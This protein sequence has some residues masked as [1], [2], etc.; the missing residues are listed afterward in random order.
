MPDAPLNIGFFTDSYTPQVNGVAISMQLLVDSLRAKGQTVHIFAPRFRGWRDTD[1]HVHRLPARRYMD[2]PPFDIALPLSPSIWRTISRLKFDI[3]HMHTPLILGGLAFGIARRR[4]IPLIYTYHTAITDYVHYAGALARAPFTPRLARWFSG[5]TANLCDEIVVPSAK[6]E[7]LLREHGVRRPIHVIP[8]G[9][10]LEAFYQAPAQRT[11]RQTLNIPPEAPILLSVGRLAP[12]KRL[13]FL[14]EAFG[15]IIRQRPEARLVFAG[16]G[17]ARAD[18]EQQAAASAYAANIIFLGMVERKRLPELFHTADVYL[19]ASTT[20]VHPLSMIEA[21]ASGLPVVAV[22]DEALTGM[23]VEGINGHF[24]PREIE[25]FSAAVLH[26]LSDPAARQAYQQASRELSRRYSVEAAAD[27]FLQL[28]R[29]AL[30]KKRRQ[31]LVATR[32][33]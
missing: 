1:P 33:A 31:N 4:H 29:H 25:P 30:E 13:D 17:S 24:S 20:E 16:D 9:I 12:E 8:N 3:L 18:L 15:A 27:T 14:I 7:P 10:D 32:P 11:F 23:V 28:Y 21:I 6:F 19:S 2:N 22:R 26:V 5:S